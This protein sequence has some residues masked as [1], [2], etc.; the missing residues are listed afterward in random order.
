MAQ[1]SG[2][3]HFLM[4]TLINL[5]LQFFDSFDPEIKAIL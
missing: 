1:G 2:I 5:I 4:N 3:M